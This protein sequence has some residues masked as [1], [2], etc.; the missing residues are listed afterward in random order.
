MLNLILLVEHLS[1]AVGNRRYCNVD[2]VKKF[3]ICNMA[4]DMS[5]VK[6]MTTA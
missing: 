3:T 4:V 5:T 2:I 6:D 1:V